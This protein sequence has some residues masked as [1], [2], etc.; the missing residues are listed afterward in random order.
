M[1]DVI[2][3]GIMRD[4]GATP[5]DV[6]ASIAKGEKVGE[7]VVSAVIGIAELIQIITIVAAALVAIVAAICDCVYKSNVKKYAAMSQSIIDG[8][9]PDAEDL[10]GLD[11]G[12]ISQN[13][14]KYLPWILGGLAA[15]LI[16]RN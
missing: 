4:F 3:T 13:T 14:K 5:E 9:T 15:V 6:C 12:L 16:L 7:V 8:G 11:D 2:C 10:E 1:Q